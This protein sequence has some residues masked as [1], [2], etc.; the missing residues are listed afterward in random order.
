MSDPLLASLRRHFG[1]LAFRPG[2]HDALHLPS[3][4]IV[5]CAG[6][7]R[8]HSPTLDPDWYIILPLFKSY[9]N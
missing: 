1:F 6:L 8:P 2:Q 4:T 5:I 9:Q 3:I 7:P